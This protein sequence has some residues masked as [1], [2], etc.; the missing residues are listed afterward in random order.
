MT[1][2][3]HHVFSDGE[4]LTLTVDTSTVPFTFRASNNQLSL[5]QGVEFEAWIEA[6][7]IPQVMSLAEDDPDQLRALVEVGQRALRGEL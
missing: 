4:K 5:H 1:H 3:F 6:V 7:V 2:T